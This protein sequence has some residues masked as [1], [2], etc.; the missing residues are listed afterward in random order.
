VPA[1]TH[2]DDRLAI[3]VA[4]TLTRAWRADPPTPSVTVEDL[5]P[6]VEQLVATGAA[7]LAWWAIR[8]EPELSGSAPGESLQLAFRSQ[9]LQAALHRRYLESVLL[10][11]NRAGIEPL[12][13]KGAA[14]SRDY[15]LPALRPYG[16]IDLAV[17]R[18]QFARLSA[19]L[20]E[21]PRPAFPV[22]IDLEH[23]FL[24]ADGT[25][26]E[27]L[28]ERSVR[29]EI[30]SSSARIP[31]AGDSFR[32]LCIHFLRAAGRR[33]LSLADIALA[34]ERTSPSIDWTLALPQ[35]DGRRRVLVAV[36]AGLAIDLLG[37]DAAGTPLEN[38][39]ASVP[40]WVRAHVLQGFEARPH[41]F[42][43][44]A[45]FGW[46]VNPTQLG[47]QIADRWPPDPLSVVVHH[48]RPLRRRPSRHLQALDFGARILV[49]AL[50][51][52]RALRLRVAS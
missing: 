12:L 24:S 29:L 30:G 13:L 49:T 17:P 50:P 14:V 10:A 46:T 51:A 52:S 36:T 16:D 1:R 28:I 26:V 23:A 43:P 9:A 48:R 8:N 7:G 21:V 25:P 39:A 2:Q 45:R 6:A 34:L 40:P 32:L 11:A 19:A 3:V 33:A 47:R 5:E 35:D 38:A 20:A 15:P 31:C 4:R 41:A 42:L 37:A 22:D 27:E 18:S 44:D